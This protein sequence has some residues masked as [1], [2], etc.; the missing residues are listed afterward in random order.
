MLEDIHMDF[1]QKQDSS[2][3]GRSLFRILE[4]PSSLTLRADHAFWQAS[5][6]RM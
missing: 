2:S 1:T 6:P 4:D 5:L 3:A